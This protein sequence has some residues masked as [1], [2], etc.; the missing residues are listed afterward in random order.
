MPTFATRQPLRPRCAMSASTSSSTG[1]RSRPSMSLRKSSFSRESSPSMCS[2]SSATVYQQPSPLY[3]LVEEHRRDPGWA[4]RD[5]QDRLRWPPSPRNGFPVDDRATGTHY[6]ET[7]SPTAVDD[8][9]GHTI[10]GRVRRGKQMIAHD[11]GTSLWTLTH[12]S[13]FARA[14]RARPD[15][16]ALNVGDG[17]RAKRY[18]TRRAGRGGR[19]A[20]RSRVAVRRGVRSS[21]RRRGRICPSAAAG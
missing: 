6:G 10:V 15:N 11:D 4:V 12:D 8:D 2:I 13:D 17:A 19:A 18:G 20:R 16:R 3:P 21:R 14:R 9:D 7:R 1:P 5:R